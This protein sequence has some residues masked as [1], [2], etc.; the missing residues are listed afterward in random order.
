MPKRDLEM[1]IRRGS[2]RQEVVDIFADPSSK[3]D[4]REHL[5]SWLEGN[6]WGRGLWA[7]FEAIAR[8]PGG[9]KQLAKVRV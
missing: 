9:W 3:S 7:E 5:V 8:E 2:Q 6:K 1:E 4:L